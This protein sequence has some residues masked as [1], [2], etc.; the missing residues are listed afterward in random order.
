MIKVT[1]DICGQD[2][3]HHQ[4]IPIYYKIHYNNGG[5]VETILTIDDCCEN[6]EKSINK[7]IKNCIKIIIDDERVAKMGLY[8]KG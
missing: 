5:N 8:T 1:C 4:P 3:P 7:K 2:L 6:C